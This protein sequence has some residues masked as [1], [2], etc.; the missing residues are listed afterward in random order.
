MSNRK[1]R[2]SALTAKIET[3][4]GTDAA[5]TGAD[6]AI[7]L[8]EIT[9]DP[10]DATNVNRDLVRGYFGGSEQLVSTAS[11]KAG[12][13]VELAGSGT[14]ATPPAFGVLLQACGMAES[15][16]TSPNR[17]EYTPVSTGLKTATM[18]YVDD[19]LIHKLLGSMGTMSLSAKVGE[20]PTMKFDFIAQDGGQAEGSVTPDYTDFKK[21]VTMTKANT[22]DITLG[23]TYA[24]GAIS[25]GTV[26]SSTG[27]EVSLGNAVAF[28]ALINQEFVDIT[29]R[30]VVGKV[31]FKLTAAEEL[32]FT[33]I[34]K[35]NTTQSLGF[36]IGTATGNKV[37]IFMPKVQLL[38]YKKS[39]MNGNRMISYDIRAVPN[40]GNDEIRLIFV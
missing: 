40:A 7:L 33:A 16:L 9:V 2:N 15:A 31:M 3:T 13:T 37:I 21:P 4:A 25:S 36:T 1:I 5:P 6:N 34:V 24:T 10:L 39:E 26:Y 28:N 8:T 30:E 29:D 18:D 22:V 11:I 14:A 35:A 17:V 20:R 27:L 23:C 38:N 12:F 32:A 19:G